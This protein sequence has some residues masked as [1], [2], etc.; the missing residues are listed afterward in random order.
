MNDRYGPDVLSST[1]SHH[2]RRPQSKQVAAQLGLV[3]E[4]VTTG[5]VGAVTRVE[6]SGGQHVVVLEDSRG[7]LRTFPLGPGF[8]I[9]G[10]PVTLVA[11]T[12]PES[13]QKQQRRR[14]A[15]GS[16]AVAD[17]PARVARTSRIW[18]EGRHDAELV[19][20]IWGDDLRIEGVVVELLQGIDHLNDRLEEFRPTRQARIGV[21]V[22][23][24]VV[25]TK[26]QRIVDEITRRWGPECIRIVG[27]P[28]VDIWQ[29]I[30]PERLGMAQWPRIPRNIEWK[31]GILAH[32]NM[33]HETQTDVAHGWASILRQVRSY[34]DLVPELLGPVENLIDFVTIDEP[35]A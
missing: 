10:K 7:S 9:D 30:K 28:F 23:H 29:A 35:S 22:D 32:L 17:A 31:R 34:S 19:E 27:H 20:K 33:P 8:W 21:L 24:L 6:K 14:T 4:E 12:R 25:G 2:R 26:E 5:W 13:V 1:T 11:P 18:V 16:L 3:V 15:S